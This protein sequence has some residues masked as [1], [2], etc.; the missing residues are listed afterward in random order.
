MVVEKSSPRVEWK[1]L[2][3]PELSRWM[4]EVLPTPESPKNTTLKIRFGVACCGCGRSP[5]RVMRAEM[6]IEGPSMFGNLMV[7]GG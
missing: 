6:D 4:R 5:L 7:L 3:S 1:V 2:N